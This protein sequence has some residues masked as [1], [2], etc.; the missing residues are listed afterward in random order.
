MAASVIDNSP[1]KTGR[2]NDDR[3]IH[4]ALRLPGK[5]TAKGWKPNKSVGPQGF[6]KGAT[7]SDPDQLQSLADEG[8]VNL[9]TLL[10]QGVISG[11]MWRM[12]TK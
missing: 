1:R 9:Q 7:V 11:S 8:K 3:M 5:S 12:A 10:D 6:E 4:Y 2:P